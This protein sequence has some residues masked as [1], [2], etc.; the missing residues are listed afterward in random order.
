MD[1]RPL[2]PIG[3]DKS[4]DVATLKHLDNSFYSTISKCF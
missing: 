3:I 1:I 4:S 2:A